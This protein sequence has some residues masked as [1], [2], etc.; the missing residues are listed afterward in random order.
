MQAYE[1][2]VKKGQNIECFKK[3]CHCAQTDAKSWFE[4][5]LIKFIGYTHY[6]TQ[7]PHRGLPGDL[8]YCKT[9]HISGAHLLTG[10]PPKY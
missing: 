9:I 8:L 10:G 7:T 3:K 4:S 6:P 2:N 5:N 1:P